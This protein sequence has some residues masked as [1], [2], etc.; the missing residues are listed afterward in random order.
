VK[1]A[2]P[3]EA[4]AGKVPRAAVR[5]MLADDNLDH[6]TSIA[7]LLRTAGYDVRALPSGTL[8][9]E[10]FSVFDPQVV[11]LDLAMPQLTGYDVAR[12]LRDDKR[13]AEVLM[14]AVTC[15]NNNTD[16][17][18]TKRAGFDHHIAKPVDPNTLTA[19]M[20]DYLAGNRPVRIDVIPDYEIQR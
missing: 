11:I 7:M 1:N 13:G 19:L 17:L 4:S 2:A 5:V 18:M 3:Q 6:A 14:I 9:L 20:R 8:L 12:I 16:R 10:Q 15:Y